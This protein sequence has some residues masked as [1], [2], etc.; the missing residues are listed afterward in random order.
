VVIDLSKLL[1]PWIAARAIGGG[2][3]LL[4]PA[5][6]HM[7]PQ[8]AGGLRVT[9]IK[10]A[11]DETGSGMALNCGTFET[12]SFAVVNVFNCGERLEEDVNR[13][14]PVLSQSY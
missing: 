3:S 13:C 9:L 10:E 4:S 1:Q 8:V 6:L 12:V 5:S 11:T 14:V 7:A 2:Y